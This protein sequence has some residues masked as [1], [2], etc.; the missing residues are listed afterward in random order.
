MSADTLSLHRTKLALQKYDELRAR[1][2]DSAGKLTEDEYVALLTAWD[3]AELDV[4]TAFALDTAD[5]NQAA[6]ARLVAP[7][8]PWLRGLVEKYT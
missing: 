1:Y 3:E 7:N 5:R 8:D 2:N 6:N 4:K